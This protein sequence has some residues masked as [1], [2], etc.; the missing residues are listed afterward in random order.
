M[1]A[2]SSRSLRHD[3]A[4]RRPGASAHGIDGSRNC[5]SVRCQCVEV[6]AAAAV[7]RGGCTS[8][9]AGLRTQFSKSGRN[10]GVNVGA[11]KE[12]IDRIADYVNQIE[13][14]APVASYFTC[15]ISSPNTPGL[16]DLQQGKIFDELL[17]RVMDARARMSRQAGMTPVLVK[18]A[19]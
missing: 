13:L 8:G 15:N 6:G 12:A 5:P 4:S 11:N 2:M 16:R 14:F 18:I 17:T 19:P 10:V 9:D 7:S 1:G 3:G